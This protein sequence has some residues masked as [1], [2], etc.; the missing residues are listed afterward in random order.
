VE[1]DESLRP[2][3]RLLSPWG[4]TAVA[5]GVSGRH[6]VANALAAAGAALAAGAP[7]DAVAAGLAAARPSPWRMALATSRSGATVLNDAYNANPTSM[8]AALRSLAALPGR[9]RV[10]VLGVMAELG[11]TSAAEH[12]RMG[13]LAAE[14]GIRVIAV[15]V[16]DY[17]VDP[18]V[19]IEAAL[20]ALGPIAEGDAILVKGSRVAGLERLANRLCGG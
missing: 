9:R 7:L 5:L 3:F 1:L 8:E 20:A 4:D 10:A 18:V 12:A 11:P 15:G 19:D 17:G 13:A 14:L 16:A 2:S 6:Q